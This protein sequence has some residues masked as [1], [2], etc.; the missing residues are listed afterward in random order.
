[1]EQHTH[2]VNEKNKKQFIYTNKWLIVMCSMHA[3]HRLL[4]NNYFDVCC[5]QSHNYHFVY[6]LLWLVFIVVY[7]DLKLSNENG[8]TLENAARSR[9][10]KICE[11]TFVWPFSIEFIN[12]LAIDLMSIG[13]FSPNSNG[14]P[15]RLKRTN[16]LTTPIAQASH[17]SL[18]NLNTLSISFESRRLAIFHEIHIN[19]PIYNWPLFRIQSIRYASQVLNGRLHF[20]CFALQLGHVFIF[21]IN[22]IAP[23]TNAF[24][25]QEGDYWL[26]FNYDYDFLRLFS[27][28]CM[29][30]NIESSMHVHRDDSKT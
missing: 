12:I 19:Q 10:R 20:C 23:P 27:P 25:H 2:R 18:M 24:V 7:R 17:I 28:A 26:I 8:S 14:W 6:Q 29:F 5:R 16:I 22:E 15:S 13:R 11:S 1:M 3:G 30:E 9:W 4:S 21:A